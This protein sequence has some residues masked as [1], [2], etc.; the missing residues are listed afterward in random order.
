[1]VSKWRKSL[2]CGV[3]KVYS[4]CHPC[5]RVRTRINTVINNN[6]TAAEQWKTLS[7][8]DKRTF[9]ANNHGV[10]KDDVATAIK[11]TVT[12]VP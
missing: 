11:T 10:L 12:E 2:A 9:V 4:R 3:N 8:V 5:N 1:M 6:E 7:T